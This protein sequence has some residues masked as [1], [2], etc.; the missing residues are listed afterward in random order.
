M[1][2]NYKK[3]NIEQVLMLENGSETL[4]LREGNLIEV[5]TDET[6]FD[7]TYTG[8][9]VFNGEER[10]MIDEEDIPIEYIT[11]IKILE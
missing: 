9:Y 1:K 7:R 10:I 3:T 2:V 6:D 4:I 11:E 8:T 5:T